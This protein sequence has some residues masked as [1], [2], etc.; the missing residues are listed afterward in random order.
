MTKVK[1]RKGFKA[2]LS[3]FPKGTLPIAL[4]D[5]TLRQF[6]KENK[7]V[8]NETMMEFALNEQ[9]APPDEFTEFIACIRIPDLKDN[10]AVIFWE[11]KLLESYYYLAVF[12]KTGELL[13]KSRIGGTK[14]NGS[15]F[16]VVIP[17]V[18]NEREIEI[19]SAKSDNPFLLPSK[20]FSTD[21]IHFNHSGEIKIPNSF[22]LM[23]DN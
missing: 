16:D 17:I 10:Y 4:N 21:H 12:S 1:A 9:D 23:D 7:P 5:V 18:K 20:G 15:L 22:L 14:S 11:G 13:K 19:R 8:S 3:K 2:F 6:S